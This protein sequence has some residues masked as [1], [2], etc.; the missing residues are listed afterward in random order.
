[1]KLFLRQ[2]QR[3]DGLREASGRQVMIACIVPA[4]PI[5]AGNVFVVRDTSFRAQPCWYP[6]IQ[7]RLAGACR[8]SSRWHAPCHVRTPSCTA[9]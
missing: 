2:S 8:A 4:A 9:I 5:E 1:M 7:T 3:Q 6:S